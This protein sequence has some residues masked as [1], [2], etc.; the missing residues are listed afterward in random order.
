MVAGFT[1]GFGLGTYLLFLRAA[2]QG[3]AADAERERL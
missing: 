3:R 2:E 1:V